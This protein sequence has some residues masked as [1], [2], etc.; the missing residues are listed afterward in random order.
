[1]LGRGGCRLTSPFSRSLTRWQ[2]LHQHLIYTNLLTGD[3][4][5]LVASRAK[6]LEDGPTVARKAPD[7]RRCMLNLEHTEVERVLGEVGGQR[8]KAALAV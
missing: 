3:D 2:L 5:S 4:E 1:M 6:L 7:Q 8:W